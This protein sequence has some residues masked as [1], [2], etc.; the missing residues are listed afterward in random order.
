MQVSPDLVARLKK[1]EESAYEEFLDR[2]GP[3]ILKFGFHMCG[4]RED[5]E[6]VLQDTLMKTWESVDKLKEPKAFTS[7]LYRVAHTACLMKR[8]RSKFLKKEIPMENL[9]PDHSGTGKKTPW[10]KL[11]ED[12]VLNSELSKKLADAIDALPENYHSVLVLRDMEGLDT[13]E[14]AKVLGLSRDVLKMRLS[15]ARAMIRRELE[16]YLINNRQ[17]S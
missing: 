1:G 16:K 13:A 3:T 9:N 10:E 4:H 2:Y 17:A 15:R 11:P 5:A 7:W 6:E 14:A 12:I 8:R